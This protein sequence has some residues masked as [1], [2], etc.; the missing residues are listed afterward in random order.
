MRV[1]SSPEL[2]GWNANRNPGQELLRPHSR[3]FLPDRAVV[4]YKLFPSPTSPGLFMSLDHHGYNLT[5]LKAET[6]SGLGRGSSPVPAGRGCCSARG[7]SCSHGW[8]AREQLWPVFHRLKDLQAARGMHQLLQRP[9][10]ARRKP[11]AG[12]CGWVHLSSSPSLVPTP[13]RDGHRWE[14]AA[15][16]SLTPALAG[17]YLTALLPWWFLHHSFSVSSISR[18]FVL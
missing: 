16:G 7:W 17:L 5:S 1:F 14:T 8:A 10:H 18:T 3:L 11:G 13:A 12:T 2:A 4:K 9:I 15:A 6:G